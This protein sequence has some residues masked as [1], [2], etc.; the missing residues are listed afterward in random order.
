MIIGKAKTWKILL[1]IPHIYPFLTTSNIL[2][3]SDASQRVDALT[4][5]L[6]TR[7]TQGVAR[8][9]ADL[10]WTALISKYTDYYKQKWL[11][12]NNDMEWKSPLCVPASKEDII[13]TERRLALDIPL[14]EDYT[15]FLRHTN[16]LTSEVD[17]WLGFNRLGSTGEVRYETW[18]NELADLKVEFQEDAYESTGVDYDDWPCLERVIAIDVGGDDNDDEGPFVWL[19]EPYLVAKARQFAINARREKQAKDFGLP[20]PEHGEAP[21]HCPMPRYAD[22]GSSGYLFL[23]ATHENSNLPPEIID[24]IAQYSL[25]DRHGDGYDRATAL[26]LCSTSRRMHEVCNA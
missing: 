11:Q 20:L 24:L 3:A 13:S 10:S 17:M 25:R 16:G 21:L 26:S 1:T 4:A 6:T 22:S 18:L 2:S 8:P 9:Y 19:I 23:P 14:P 5:A 12:R 15:V 7:M